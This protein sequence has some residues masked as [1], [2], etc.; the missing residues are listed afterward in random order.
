MKIKRQ[1]LILLF[2]SISTLVIQEVFSQIENCEQYDSTQKLCTKCQTG[3]LVQLQQLCVQQCQDYQ[4]SNGTSC[5]SCSSSITN[6]W[7]CTILN[8]NIICTACLS[9]YKLSQDYQ[10]CY[11]IINNCSQYSQDYSNCQQCAT[12]FTLSSNSL[13]C[14]SPC[15]ANTPGYI[16]IGTSCV[17]C[18]PSCQTCS[19][20][21]TNCTSCQPPNLF[22]DLNLNPA[23]QGE[24]TCQTLCNNPLT[25]Y[26]DQN[27][28]CQPCRSSCL[29]CVNNSYYCTSCYKDKFLQILPGQNFGICQSTC[30]TGYFQNQQTNNCDSCSSNCNQCFNSQQCTSCSSGY[31]LLQVSNSQSQCVQQNSIVDGY[32]FDQSSQQFLKCSSSCITCQKSSQFC[33]SCQSPLLLDVQGGLC[34]PKCPINKLQTNQQCVGCSALGVTNCNQCEKNGQN[35][36]CTSCQL[37]F[38]LDY[39]RCSKCDSSCKDCLGSAT[40]CTLCFYPYIL[41]KNSCN[42]ACSSGKYVDNNQ[43]CQQ[44]N[45][46]C[47]SCFGQSYNCTSCTNKSQFIDL[48]SPTIPGKYTC[49]NSCNNPIT[50][51]RDANNYCQPCSSSCYQCIGSANN[52]ASCLGNLFLQPSVDN[53]NN[54]IQI[55]TQNCQITS[56]QDPT[57]G[58]CKPCDSTCYSCSSSLATNCTSCKSPNILTVNLLQNF[59]C[60]QSCNLANGYF[61]SSRNFTINN[62]LQQIP[63]CEQCSSSCLLCQDSPS[64]CIKCPY[65]QSL[66]K[67]NCIYSC[68]AGYYKQM[69]IDGKSSVCQQCYS[70]CK[71]CS[72]ATQICSSCID[73]YYKGQD[74]KC[75]PCEF[76]CQNCKINA[77]TCISCFDIMYL[78]PSTNRCVYTCDF[79]NGYYTQI[80]TNI[81]LQCASS[82]LTC[83]NY[84]TQCVV[85]ADGLLLQHEPDPTNNTCVK[86]CS[87][88]YYKDQISSS[89]CYQCNQACLQCTDQYTCTSCP[90]QQYLQQYYLNPSCTTNGCTVQTTCVNTCYNGF[91]PY[92]NYCQQCDPKCSLCIGMYQCQACASSIYFLQYN[93]QTGNTICQSTC[94]AGYIADAN[95]VCQ[96]CTSNCLTCATSTSCAVCD[97]TQNY[98]LDPSSGS[99][100]CAPGY[101]SN[102]QVCSQCLNNFYTSPNCKTCV[103]DSFFGYNC[104]TCSDSYYLQSQLYY[105]YLIKNPPGCIPLIDYPCNVSYYSF[106]ICLSCNGGTLNNAKTC[107]YDSVNGVIYALTCLDGYYLYSDLTYRG[108]CLQCNQNCLTCSSYTSCQSCQGGDYLDENN[109]CRKLCFDQA[110]PL[111][112]YLPIKNM[113]SLYSCFYSESDIQGNC[114]R[115]SQCL[116]IQNSSCISYQC[117]MC[118][119]GYFLDSASGNCYQKCPAAYAKQSQSGNFK[120]VQISNTNCKLYDQYGNNCL[121]CNPSYYLLNNQSSTL[122]VQKCPD[123]YYSRTDITLGDK[124]YKCSSNCKTC[125]Y[126]SNHCLTCDQSSKYKYIMITPH[127][128]TAGGSKQ[129]CVTTCPANSNINQQTL[130]CFTCSSLCS[131]CQD[132]PNKCND[133]KDGTLIFP[134]TF[135]DPNIIQS[136]FHNDP[137]LKTE[138]FKL[139]LKSCSQSELKQLGISTIKSYFA[140]NSSPIR[141]C[142]I[143][144]EGCTQCN[145]SGTTVNQ[146]NF[147]DILQYQCSQCDSSLNYFSNNYGGCKLAVC[148]DGFKDAQEQ[149]DDGNNTNYDGCNSQCQIE[150][151]WKCTN[152]LGKSSLCK[153]ICGDSSIIGYKLG[154]KETCDAGSNQGK[155]TGCSSQCTTIPGYF[156][157]IPQNSAKT[158]CGLPC[159]GNCKKCQINQDGVT[160]CVQCANPNSFINGL[161]CVDQCQSGQLR[162]PITQS[163]QQQCPSFYSSIDYV[164]NMCVSYCPQNLYSINKQTYFECRQDCPVGY[165]KDY[166]ESIQICSQCHKSCSTCSSSLPTDCMSCSGNLLYHVHD[167]YNVCKPACDPG[168]QLGVLNNQSVCVPCL[169][170][171]TACAPN[172]YLFNGTCSPTCDIPNTSKDSSTWTCYYNSIPSVS[173]Q[174][175]NTSGVYGFVNDYKLFSVIDQIY[176][177]QSYLWTL[178][179]EISAVSTQF[180]YG[181]AQNQTTLVIKGA[182]LI[183]NKVY[184]IQLQAVIN[185]AQYF[186]TIQIATMQNPNIQLFVTPTKG[187]YLTTVFQFKTL[188]W[189]SYLNKTYQYTLVGLSSINTANNIQIL[190]GYG[191]SDISKSFVFPLQSQ[192]QIYTIQLN[193]FTQDFSIVPVT[194]IYVSQN[195]MPITNITSYIMSQKFT[196]VLD[197]QSAALSFNYATQDAINSISSNFNKQQL[198]YQTIT[199]DSTCTA[200]DNCNGNGKCIIISSQI[201]CNCDSKYS[202]QYCQY[203]QDELA[204]IQNVNFKILSELER[205]GVD[206]TNSY[207]YSMALD[208]LTS[209][210]DA[211][212]RTTIN[213]LRQNFRQLLQLGAV[214][215]NA[216][217]VAIDGLMGYLQICQ[218]SYRQNYLL[219]EYLYG[220]EQ[221]YVHSDLLLTGNNYNQIIDKG[222]QDAQFYNKDGNSIMDNLITNQALYSLP[223]DDGHYFGKATGA[224]IS[225]NNYQ[226]SNIQSLIKYN[227][228]QLVRLLEESS[229][230]KDSNDRNLQTLKSNTV[231]LVDFSADFLSDL[232]K[233]LSQQN[234]NSF[235]LAQIEYTNTNP[236]IESSQLIYS[237]VLKIGIV[238]QTNNQIATNFKSQSGSKYLVYLQKSSV[239]ISENAVCAMYNQ[240]SQQYE[241]KKLCALHNQTNAFYY[242]CECSAFGYITIKEF[243][244]LSNQFSNVS[245]KSFFQ[246]ILSNFGFMFSISNIILLLV[247]LLIL[248][249]FKKDKDILKEDFKA[250]HPLYSILFI[251]DIL[252]PREIRLMLFFLTIAQQA[253]FEA[254]LFQ[255]DNIQ[256]LGASAIPV[257][258]ICGVLISSV[259]NYMTGLIHFFT[260]FKETVYFRKWLPFFL[261]VFIELI[262]Y[263]IGFTKIADNLT[264]QIMPTWLSTFFTGFLLDVLIL[265]MIFMA[266]SIK[267]KYIRNLVQIRGFFSGKIITL[268]ELKKEKIQVHIENIQKKLK[269]IQDQ[270]FIQFIDDKQV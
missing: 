157:A 262:G 52:C 104:Q 217:P 2:Y 210:T 23:F 60:A 95:N 184:K 10:K 9:N 85:C 76:P 125:Q 186:A 121:Q 180:F 249:I 36:V 1:Q 109:I 19:K 106:N 254:L 111:Q 53:N 241:D 98:A 124:C 268:D 193:I 270:R 59:Y 266:L 11:L 6:C 63:T 117:S 75:Y 152:D 103:V 146:G 191:Q 100:V 116:Q 258:G 227:L 33:T 200:Q 135:Q 226:T 169:K 74:G 70:T 83:Q 7:K 238:N 87:D 5:I 183:S 65:A 250:L 122:C 54:P 202:G 120:C 28:T 176:Q 89:N 119:S 195:K 211:F 192:D 62:T 40:S 234:I 246:R 171:C 61:M 114:V 134:L 199:N 223:Q 38:Y 86:S 229:A 244:A 118:K 27:Q 32:Y 220:G 139:C 138:S 222:L 94:D 231:S 90:N 92:G 55:C 50:T 163:C 123:G 20:T 161:G 237:S 203:T 196:S 214:S 110:P 64:N 255:S 182:N 73:E 164:A 230:D 79:S 48:I 66:Y 247:L 21:T 31:S 77:T 212:N 245:Q 84:P 261:V 160:S 13:S 82:C 158:Q 132:N 3:Y 107:N 155:I 189:P 128:L 45:T 256:N 58:S 37:G 72:D 149:C 81:C 185:S 150:S 113:N 41:D 265:D 69:S 25:S 204:Q 91:Y 251:N 14:L 207:E 49:K 137:S 167:F 26:V 17:Q 133:C 151:G 145:P 259:L 148:G 147:L 267:V 166:Y 93:R 67:N 97:Y 143:C 140:N 112:Q 240:T 4:Y 162:N 253:F 172:L 239:S 205:Y 142:Q 208:S 263:Y 141:T 213:S 8:S 29:S 175:E 126:Q 71:T 108:I 242:I 80:N 18:S 219:K 57:S 260:V 51:Y 228:S 248:L 221:D 47:S 181:V 218:Y 257:V 39:G 46:E 206:S 156:C 236:F 12:N 178:P 232:Q 201:Q 168:F 187:S 35:I 194:Q 30:N 56:Y 42:Q 177:V 130:T 15:D 127:T 179:E 209:L 144:P 115:A 174:Q 105:Q 225:I 24:Y 131:S 96:L 188:G 197:I 129:I 269:Q 215:S 34:L 264:N 136:P 101:I 68:P 190:S 16:Q 173:I 88:G 44:C 22:L 170:Q 78:L 224:K 153:T 216:L 102:G 165:F 233:Y 235:S 154:G 99:C 198:L 159:L 252:N 243:E 43:V